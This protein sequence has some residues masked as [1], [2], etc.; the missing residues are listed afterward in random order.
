MFKHKKIIIAAV[1]AVIVIT[2]IIIISAQNQ[3]R[4]VASLQNS[5]YEVKTGNITETVN[6]TG[7]ISANNSFD[8]TSLVTG[9][10]L[11]S[12]FD[13]GDSVNEGDVLYTISSKELDKQIKT[14]KIALERCEEAY[15]QSISAEN[16]LITT[17]PYSGKVQKLYVSKGDFIANGTKIAD[18][19]NNQSLILKIPF[20]AA[21]ID[22][23]RVGDPAGITLAANSTQLSGN[24]S[25]IYDTTDTLEGFK[26]VTNLEITVN[27][28]GA[29]DKGDKAYASVNNI[30][31]N[32]AGEFINYTE[33]SVVSSGS[34]Q[35]AE[36]NIMEGD[37]VSYGK[38]VLK[39]KNDALSN[40]VQN[41]AIA[42]KEAKNSVDALEKQLDDY[43][44]I[45]PI[46]GK[47]VS[48][49]V[50]KGDNAAPASVL[51]T[52]S[53]VDNLY[54]DVEIDEI[55]ISKVNNGQRA[56]LKAD[57]LPGEIFSG[58]VVRV[59]DVGVA[60]NGVTYYPV[61]VKIDHT[62]KLKVSMN[63]S[64]DI[65]C[66]VKENVLLMPKDALSGDKV[67]LFENGKLGEVTV[68]TGIKDDTYIEITKG[69]K[70][71]DKISAGK[72]Q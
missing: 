31:C 57:A 71:G 7:I 43:K 61:R 28:P 34:G 20:N 62:D 39:L 53:D 1:I 14:A 51:M 2:V 22:K 8:I 21:D 29:V 50:K 38:T 37:F 15:R 36:L 26:I 67:Q 18:I 49:N 13:T 56:M 27:N 33:K 60:K 58:E 16:D 24:V 32:S 17:S 47:V 45:S 3:S 46:S 48:R 55:Y 11:L 9:A 25:R 19:V 12:S 4:K 10:V 41:S 6:G 63:L 52:V 64:V 30:A 5:L 42:V 54:I 59:S 35:I 68:K 40:A 70:P 69:L 23:I 66:G 65:I 44:I 72:T